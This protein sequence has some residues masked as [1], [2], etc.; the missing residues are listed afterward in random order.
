MESYFAGNKHSE[1][2]RIIR[3]ASLLAID[4]IDGIILTSYVW[5]VLYYKAMTLRRG[6]QLLIVFS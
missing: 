3:R 6:N 4:G 5:K 2:S 1:I